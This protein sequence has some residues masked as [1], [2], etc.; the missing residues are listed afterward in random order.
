MSI[1]P[2]R[3]AM[4]AT[5][6]GTES[7]SVAVIQNQPSALRPQAQSRFYNTPNLGDFFLTYHQ[8]AFLNKGSCPKILITDVIGHTQPV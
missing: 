3:A 7:L 1:F 2:A 4:T 5:C 6:G 8:H